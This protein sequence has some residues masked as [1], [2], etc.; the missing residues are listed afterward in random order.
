MKKK[1]F[2]Y[3]L[4]MGLLISIMPAY[5]ENVRTAKL[6]DFSGM[7]YIKREASE[8]KV[9]AFRNMKLAEGDT[10]FTGEKSK[11]VL[12]LDDDKKVT[13]SAKSTIVLS[14]LSS[15][16]GS[17]DTAITLKNGGVGTKI[18]K[19]LDKSSKYKIKTPTTVMGVRGTEFYV[20]SSIYEKGLSDYKKVNKDYWRQLISPGIY[21]TQGLLSLQL[22]SQDN[23]ALLKNYEENADYAYLLDRPQVLKIEEARPKLMDFRPQGLH[24]EFLEELKPSIGSLIQKDDYD[25]AQER[26]DVK[27]RLIE[28]NLVDVPK[29]RLIQSDLTVYE[30]AEEDEEEEELPA[31]SLSKLVDQI[32]LYDSSS[33]IPNYYTLYNVTLNY[34]VVGDRAEFTYT[35]TDGITYTGSL[36]LSYVE[37]VGTIS[38][39]PLYSN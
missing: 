30:E 11:A 28:E 27:D 8:K 32:Y 39:L 10:L 1:L 38:G 31:P 9:K 13:V 20:Q 7:V 3:M 36:A 17:T 4:I 37:S 5:A 22:L 34:V 15:S 18:N 25:R 23:S 33:L 12:E 19:K 6:V 21:F 16:A 26:E 35:H 24:R 2:I 29:S 14:E